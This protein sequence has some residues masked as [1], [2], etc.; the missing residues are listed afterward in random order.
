M[1]WVDWI[2]LAFKQER[3]DVKNLDY[4]EEMEKLNKLK[5]Q[6]INEKQCKCSANS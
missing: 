2:L 3:G 1:V 4:K 5:N 6:Q